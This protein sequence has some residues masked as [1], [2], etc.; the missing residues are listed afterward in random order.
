MFLF[1]CIRWCKFSET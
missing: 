1:Y